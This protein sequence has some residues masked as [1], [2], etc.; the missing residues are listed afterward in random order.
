MKAAK[1]NKFILHISNARKNYR[2]RKR[3]SGRWGMLEVAG[4]KAGGRIEETE[5]KCR[6]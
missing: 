6:E 2:A 5:I 1:Y 3:E 4:A